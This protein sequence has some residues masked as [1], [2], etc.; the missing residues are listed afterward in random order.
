MVDDPGP[1][2]RGLALVAHPHP[3]HGGTLAN[4]VV[5]TLA[6]T[7]LA[8]GYAAARPNFRG[9]GQSEGAFDHGEGELADMLAVAA[10]LRPRFAGLPLVLL[11]FSFGAYVQARAAAAL[12][13]ARVVLVAPA[14][15][16]FAFGPPPARSL[17]V[18]GG[19]DELVPLACVQ[20]WSR[21]TPGAAELVV[22]PGAGHHFHGKLKELRRE[23]GDRCRC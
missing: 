1:G 4:K 15:N 12:A 6:K 8:A 2:R 18:H 9:V 11:G 16:L 3:L 17:V 19:D 5:V 13:P 23:V 14:V 20:A 10:F 7:A 22:L 21:A